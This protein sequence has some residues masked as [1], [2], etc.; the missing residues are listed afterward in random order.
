MMWDK[1]VGTFHNIKYHNTGNLVLAF[2]E[3]GTRLDNNRTTHTMADELFIFR[4]ME[5]NKQ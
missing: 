2:Q 4:G 5:R 1:D 3:F